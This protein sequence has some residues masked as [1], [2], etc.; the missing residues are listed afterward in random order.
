M[1][2]TSRDQSFEHELIWTDINIGMR[3]RF[4]DLRNAGQNARMQGLTPQADVSLKASVPGRWNA[5]ALAW[6]R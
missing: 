5:L 2:C 4:L 3:S 6:K 1:C